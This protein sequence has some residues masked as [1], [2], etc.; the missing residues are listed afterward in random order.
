MKIMQL[1]IDKEF[2]N[3]ISPLSKDEYEQLKNNIIQEGCRDALICWNGTIVDGHNRY[4]I[5]REHN[6]EFRVEEKSFSSK[7]QVLDWIINNQLGRRNINDSQKAYLRGLQYEREKKKVTTLMELKEKMVWKIHTIK[8]QQEDWLNSTKY[9]NG[10]SEKT[11]D[12]QKPSIPL[13]KM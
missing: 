12:M 3:L 11:Q 13:A 9:M 1:K 4:E 5:C 6:I 8:K 7:G 10:Q 2:K